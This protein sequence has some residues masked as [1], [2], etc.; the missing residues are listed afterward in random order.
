MEEIVLNIRDKDGTLLTVVSVGKTEIDGFFD[1]DGRTMV[2]TA[3]NWI[4]TAINGK[5]INEI[6]RNENTE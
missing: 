2:F 3:E 5:I 1:S 6:L 4:T